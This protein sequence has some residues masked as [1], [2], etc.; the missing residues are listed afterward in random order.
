MIKFLGICNEVKP[1]SED[2]RSSLSAL[3][4]KIDTLVKNESDETIL[5]VLNTEIFMIKSIL[6]NE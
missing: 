4:L 2:I 1:L 3:N 5:E 6:N